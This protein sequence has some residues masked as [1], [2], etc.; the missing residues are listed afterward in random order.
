ALPNQ[1]KEDLTKDINEFLIL[2][3][4][5]I[6]TY[7]LMYEEGTILNHMKETGKIIPISDDVDREYF[8]FINLKLEE[9]GYHRYEISNFSK[10]G[11]ESKHNMLYWNDFEYIGLGVSSHGYLNQYRYENTC[12][13]NEYIKMVSSGNKSIINSE[14]ID[15]KEEKFEYIILNLRKV[16]GFSIEEFNKKFNVDFLLEYEKEIRKMTKYGTLTVEMGRVYLTEYG[17]DVSNQVYGEFM[18]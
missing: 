9:M 14:F 12:D 1:N 4:E 10:K 2:N 16:E 11:Y 18:K 15:K 8:H 13:I 5:H 17:F 3:P 7:S 6:S